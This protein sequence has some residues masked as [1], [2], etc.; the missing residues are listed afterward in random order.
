[1]DF[2]SHTH[3]RELKPVTFYLQTQFDNFLR[4]SWEHYTEMPNQT[5]PQN[6]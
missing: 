2:Y 3:T 1:M 4:L 6:F 5:G